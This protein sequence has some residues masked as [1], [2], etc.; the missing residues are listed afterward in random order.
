ML[1][2]LG[3]GF[4]GGLCLRFQGGCEDKQGR[5][6]VVDEKGKCSMLR[7]GKGLL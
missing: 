7:R 5:G 4:S 1:Q 6:S 2:P 3:Q